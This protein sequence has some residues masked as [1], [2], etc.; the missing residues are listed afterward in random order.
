MYLRITHQLCESRIGCA[1]LHRY[2]CEMANLLL[3]L[4]VICAGVS[5]AFYTAAGA[6]GNVP[7][8]ASDICSAAPTFC[9]YPQ[10]MAFAAAGLAAFGILIKFVSALR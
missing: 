2:G 10:Q 8:W 9:H 5:L 7:S 6:A 4:A 1:D 3:L